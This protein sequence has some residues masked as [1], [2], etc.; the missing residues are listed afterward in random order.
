M[1][2]ENGTEYLS[3]IK[4][5][6]QECRDK[7]L[8]VSVAQ[9]DVK[10]DRDKSPIEQEDPDLYVRVVN[11]DSSGITIRGAKIQTSV[12]TSAHEII[13]L[14]TRNMKQGEEKYAVACAVPANS[15]G[16]TMIASGYGSREG[17][18]FENPISS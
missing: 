10:G 17:N 15:P 8:A 3:R 7:D 6:Y 13:V 16:L 18:E 4:N 11:Q 9:T 5:F 2:K 1:D 14:P 12:S